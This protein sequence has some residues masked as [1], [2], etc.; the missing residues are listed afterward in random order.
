M[1]HSLATAC[2]LSSM[3]ALAA[4]LG[5]VSNASG[6]QKSEGPQ[7]EPG[8]LGT[9]APQSTDVRMPDT[10]AHTDTHG[11]NNQALLALSSTRGG[12]FAAVWRDQRDGML[13]LYLARLNAQADLRE[14]ER[15]IHA[16]HSGRR[17]D[18]GVA[19]GA[20]DAGAVVWVSVTE[21]GNTPW[22]RTFDAKGEFLNADLQLV[23]PDSARPPARGRDGGGRAPAVMDLGDGGY[24]VAWTQAGHVKLQEF[25]P[26]GAAR[27]AAIVLA[28]NDPPTEAGVALATSAKSGLLC[29]WR[30]K[31]GNVALHYDG[32]SNAAAVACGA[33][34][35]AKLCADADTGYWALFDQDGRASLRHLD[36]TG[37]PDREELHPIEGAASGLD[38]AV[39]AN[40][41]AIL[42]TRSTAPSGAARP[43]DARGGARGA[44][45]AEAAPDPASESKFEVLLLD[46][47]GKAQ[48]APLVV[49]ASDARTS[50][51]PRI[52]SNG[53]VLL[54]AWTDARNGDP[55]V[56]A[57]IVD[58][59]AAGT[60]ANTPDPRLGPERRVNTDQASADQ[61]NPMLAS[62]KERG[63]IVWQDRRDGLSRIYA[64]LFGLPAS[65]TSAEI[66]VPAPLEGLARQEPLGCDRPS[67]AMRANGDF[68]VLW[69]EVGDKVATLHAQ[70]FHADG[71][72]A[73]APVVVDEG[74]N[75]GGS[76]PEAIDALPG[77]R[78]YA[79]VWSRVPKGGIWTRRMSPDGEL[80][81][82]ARRVSEERD[83]DCGNPSI[84]L[85]DDQ[86]SLCAWDVH[87][88][89]G[90]WSLRARFLDAD[91][92]LK[93]DEISFE[94]YRYDQDWDPFVAPAAN[95]GF[96]LAWCAGEPTNGG[97]DVVARV[98][99]SQGHAGGPFL[100][101]SSLAQEQDFPQVIRLADKSYVVTWEDD[102][103]YF[104]HT[105]LRRIRAN[106]REIGPI[107]R[108]NELATRA[109][110]DRTGPALAPLGDGLVGAWNDRRRSLGWDV[111]M[112]IL[113]PHFDAV[114]MP[115]K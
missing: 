82:V 11:G 48:S 37:K 13:G 97:R 7:A 10:L 16:P 67:A 22:L 68:A 66:A 78:G 113:G 52:A 51:D 38:L 80:T 47:D 20:G 49:P 112:R 24:A 87:P 34:V 107:V 108:M 35:I 62:A 15:P 4:L 8:V 102:I 100:P 89:G 12:G 23:Q 3:L 83:Q 44:K 61:N 31:N 94:A 69:K 65:F 59:N 29:A 105:Y 9:V 1:T 88:D 17:R 26:A 106:G 84:A 21:A 5:G 70:A 76:F 53:A 56:Y 25:G 74:Q 98:Y 19:L 28:P 60:D 54:V 101:I 77:N 103:S 79:L 27:G 114:D 81:G 41:I 36:A 110:E 30:T 99:D 46:R 33:G 73:A 57:R 91:G 90:A 42:Y 111:Y 43:G 104:D 95:N 96:V 63:V 85:L 2:Y 40:G 50:G 92:N 86:R 14:P 115:K 39:H 32:K 72:P 18:P 45:R 55:D 58:P 71:K 75:A 93:G 6:A 109:V 64:R